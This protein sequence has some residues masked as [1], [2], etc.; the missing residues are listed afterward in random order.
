MPSRRTF[1]RRFRDRQKVWEGFLDWTNLY[2]GKMDEHT[3]R[4]HGG[5]RSR[6]ADY[7]VRISGLH[8]VFA[9][10]GRRGLPYDQAN[11]CVDGVPVFHGATMWGDDD[12]WFCDQIRKA[13][14]RRPAFFNVFLHN[15]TFP[16]ERIRKIQDMLGPDYV[17]VTPSQLAALYGQAQG[18]KSTLP[19][20][21]GTKE[22]P[23]P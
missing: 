6:M 2:M 12:E 18:G 19:Q 17:W 20:A 3:V 11:Y 14:D 21:P 22:A 15:W 4:P 7:A 9:D 8:S 1:G 16:W 23:R 10:Y 13:T 5:D